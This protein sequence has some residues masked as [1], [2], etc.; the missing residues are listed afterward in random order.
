MQDPVKVALWRE[1]TARYHQCERL[2]RVA[3]SQQLRATQETTALLMRVTQLSIE[4]VSDVLW[5]L[6]RLPGHASA[7]ARMEVLNA[8][9]DFRAAR[10]QVA[11]W[12]PPIGEE[13]AY[14]ERH[15]PYLSAEMIAGGLEELER[16]GATLRALV[17]EAGER[18]ANS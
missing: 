7:Q 12:M 17:G 11:A 3:F 5:E 16:A 15:A 6:V 18:I 2:L 1:A 9:Q 13:D 4:T 14:F 8:I 10:R